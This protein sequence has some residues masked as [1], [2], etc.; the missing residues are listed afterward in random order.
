M[1]AV[2]QPSFLA[3]RTQ[4]ASDGIGKPVRRKEDARLLTGAGRFGD[5]VSLPGQ[6]YAA[7]VRSPHAHARIG[8][9][10]TAAARAIP[11]CWRY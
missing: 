5:D 2:A 8:P 3:S 11:V 7:F 6:A 4:I 9:I 10:D 1:E